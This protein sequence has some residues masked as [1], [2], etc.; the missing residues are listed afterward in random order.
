M[1]NEFFRITDE[2]K[3]E[4]STLARQ[5]YL[6][7]VECTRT[8][9]PRPCNYEKENPAQMIANHLECLGKQTQARKR[10][11]EKVT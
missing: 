8:S 10:G 6:V 11:G 1:C 5:I 2:A 4:D 3:L 9:H 7:S